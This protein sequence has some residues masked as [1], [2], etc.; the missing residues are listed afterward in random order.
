MIVLM[1]YTGWKATDVLRERSDRS[2]EVSKLSSTARDMRIERLVYSIKGDDQQAA[3]WLEALERTNSQLRTMT[4]KFKS[5]INRD[6]LQEASA[7]MGR[8]R[9]FYDQTV[10]ATQERGKQLEAA[11]SSASTA[12]DLILKL[13]AGADM[14]AGNSEVLRKLTALSI[15]MQDMRISSRVYLGSPTKD[16]ELNFRALME[17]VASEAEAL[18]ALSVA[19]APVQALANL[20]SDY[21]QRFYSL[22]DAQARVDA[23]QAGITLNITALLKI[24]DEMDKI[25]NDFRASDAGDVQQKITLWLLLS[26]VLGALAA[27]L[28]TRSIVQPLNETVAIV[29]KIAGGDFTYQTASTRRDE[30]GL[31]QRSMLRMAS[32]LRDLIGQVKDGVVQVASAAEELAA[33]TEQ[34]SVGVNAQ[35]L[36]TDQIAT[37]MQQMTAATHDVSQNA[38][39]AVGTAQT[40]SRMAVQ[41]GQIVDE[42]RSQIESLAREMDTTKTRMTS[43]RVNT[44][45]IGG[46]LDV[47]KAVADQTNLLAL[48]AAIEAARAGEAGRGFAVVADEVRGLAVRTRKSTDEIAVLINELQTSTDNMTTVLEQNILLTDRSAELSREASEVLLNVTAS[49]REIEAMNEQIA[50]ATEQQSSVGEEIGRSVINVRDISEQTA[51]ASEE[52]AASSLELARISAHLHHMAVRFSV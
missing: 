46:V 4:P 41:G 50:V 34:T 47:I 13:S 21:R 8:Y 10:A 36:E 52:T 5:P 51:S 42:T 31:L 33:V 18:K 23:A 45:S 44:Q 15:A 43:L 26:I 30:L 32:G 49:V 14:D 35:K 24:T 11:A 19:G 16:N 38:A 39:R 22:I 17:T 1:A 40:A 27:W 28:I 6:L 7:I 12:D 25:Q 37:A 48:N 29:E 20:L 9:E 2:G 3:K